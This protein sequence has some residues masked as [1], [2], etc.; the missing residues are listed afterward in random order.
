MLIDLHCHTKK[1]KKGDGIGRNVTLKLFRSKIELADVKIVAVTNHNAFDFGQYTELKEAVSDICQVWPGVEIDVKGTLEKE[2]FHL[3]VVCNSEDALNFD[4]TVSELFNGCDIN[5]CVHS[6]QDVC[7]KFKKLDA[8]YIP[9][10]HNKRPAISEVDR[11]KLISIIGDESRAF[12]EHRDHRTLGVL[13]NGMLCYMP[14]IWASDCTDALQRARIQNGYSYGYPQSVLG[15]HV[16]ASPNHQTLRRIPLESRFAIACAGVLGYECNLSDLSA[17]EL[18]EIREEVKLY[19]EWREVLQFGQFYRLKG[20][21]VKGRFDTEAV[22][23]NIVSPDGTRAVGI[24]LQNQVLPNYSHRYLKTR[25]LLE[26][27]IYHVYNRS[28]KY[29]IRRMGDLI[30]T[31]SPIPVKQDSLLHGALSHLVQLD[32][33]KEDHI[34][35]GSILN[36][37]GIPLASGYQGTGFEGN[38]AFYQDYDARIFLIEEAAPAEGTGIREA[39]SRSGGK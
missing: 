31:V 29:D 8:I 9:H 10:F 11:Q 27:R 37:A 38:T 20:H 22:R 24:T 3:I 28:L 2:K 39:V 4:S 14:Q 35:T 5:S 19:K 1:T 32:G 7:K 16:S 30:N 6:L 34:V 26:D 15:A 21:A 12:I 25:G 13:A 17:G 18:A 33:E 23:W 36:K